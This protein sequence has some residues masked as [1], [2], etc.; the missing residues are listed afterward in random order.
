MHREVCRPG[1]VAR[2]DLLLTRKPDMFL[3]QRPTMRFRPATPGRSRFAGTGKGRR[4]V[5]DAAAVGTGSPRPKRGCAPLRSRYSANVPAKTSNDSSSSSSGEDIPAASS[6]SGVRRR[7]E[8]HPQATEEGSPTRTP[9]RAASS[10]T[11]PSPRAGAES[12][13]SKRTAAAPGDTLDAAQLA[14]VHEGLLW[15]VLN[16]V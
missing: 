11:A 12:T 2:A 15:H 10:Q 13:G 16:R 3:V 8:G 6:G 7:I 5:P 4:A 9:G 1:T 14:H